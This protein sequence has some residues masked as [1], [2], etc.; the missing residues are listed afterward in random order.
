MRDHAHTLSD[1]RVPTLSIECEPCGRV[2]PLQ[3]RQAHGTVRRRQAPRATHRTRQLPQG[4]IAER[5]RLL[6]RGL[7]K[8]FQV[9]H[10]RQ[11]RAFLTLPSVEWARVT[12]ERACR[13]WLAAGPSGAGLALGPRRASPAPRAADRGAGRG[14]FGRLQWRD[15]LPLILRRVRRRL[16]QSSHAK[17]IV[18]KREAHPPA[19]RASSQTCAFVRKHDR[20]RGL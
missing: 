18:A 19:A 13:L 15:G 14:E 2:V 5:L 7:R 10:L 16:G 11:H 8:R 1:F 4:A 20:S 17:D 6:P 12:A 3:H 9:E